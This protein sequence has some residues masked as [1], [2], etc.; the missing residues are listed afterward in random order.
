MGTVY[1]ASDGE[2]E[3]R[4]AVKVIRDDMVGSLNGADRFR[5]EARVA[6]SF[7]HPNVVTVYDFGITD[8][9]RGYLV[10]ERLNGATL[11][12]TMRRDG[13]VPP[14]RTLH[15]MR[16][17]CQAVDAAHRRQLIHRDLKPDNIFLTK[18]Q[19]PKVLDF[20]IAKF[21]RPALDSTA[22]TATGAVV[23]TLGTCRRNRFALARHTRHGT[24]GRSRSSPTRCWRANAHLRK[25]TRS[26]GLPRWQREPGFA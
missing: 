24:S 25:R 17:V 13:R 16:G 23:G 15:I 19:V 26:I 7:A 21:V 12:E 14:S 8:N 3:R 22:L 6:A 9:G 10:M 2:L 1:E 20:G 5:H 18:E 4:V 11:R